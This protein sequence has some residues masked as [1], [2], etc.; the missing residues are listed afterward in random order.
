MAFRRNRDW[1]P[2]AAYGL[3]AQVPSGGSD[4]ALSPLLSFLLVTPVLDNADGSGDPQFAIGTP[5]AT[6]GVTAKRVRG[7]IAIGLRTAT[8]AA[9][10]A[11]TF[12]RLEIYERIHVVVYDISDGSVA[13]PVDS[14]N[15]AADA[16]ERFLWE[17]KSARDLGPYLPG[18]DGFFVPL[19]TA[20]F[21][22]PYY[23]VVDVQAE[24]RIE[25]GFALVYSIQYRYASTNP[26]TWAA[27]QDVTL[28]VTPNLRTY[29]TV[30]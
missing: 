18:T 10:P 25:Q 24:R 16:N 22:H 27:E 17:R 12:A 14:L 28:Y 20:D 4:S 3:G 26:A 30:R 19:N 2:A 23:R 6:R 15:F 1:V 21:V 11:S 29:C 7:D 8:D 13:A 5:D 9:D